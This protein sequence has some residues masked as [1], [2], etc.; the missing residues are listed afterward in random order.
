MHSRRPIA[1]LRVWQL[2]LPLKR[3][4]SHAAAHRDLSNPIIVQV[5][6]RDG[7]VGHGETHP[8]PYVTGENEESVIDDIRGVFCPMLA[9]VGPTHFGEAIEAAARL[10]TRDARGRVITAAR[11]A[12]ELAM[13]DAYSRLFERSI[14]SIAGWVSQT[15]LGPPGSARRARYSGVISSDDPRKATRTARLFRLAGFRHFK[16][17]VGDENDDARVGAVAKVLGRGLTR[18]DVTLRL[19][20]N[21]AWSLD[22]ATMKLQDWES[23]P[24]TCVEQPLS[25]G[26]I[27]DWTELTC[28]TNLPLMADES[29]V[30]VED[31]DELIARGAASWFNVRISKNG[32]LIPALELALRAVDSHLDVI[33]GCM[34][35]ETSILSAAGQWFLR[36]VPGVEIAEGCFGR[37]LLSDDV[38]TRPLCFGCG[39]SWRPMDG[40]GLGVE[41]REDR[42]ARY[43]ITEPLELPL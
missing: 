35:G 23:L 21:G 41:V 5:V 9:E 8:R 43:A 17:K 7:V 15:T 12:V 2:A 13:L 37:F 29:L 38:V 39:G 18:G 24:I 16:V 27:E 22:E 40:P 11:A 28:R 42:L 26:R 30:T 34:V 10:P 36:L 19:D 33:L 3:K 4:F 20:A 25:R 31:A 6:T 32:G 1:R 14:A